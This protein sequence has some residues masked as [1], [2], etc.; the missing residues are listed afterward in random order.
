MKWNK[1]NGFPMCQNQIWTENPL[2]GEKVEACHGAKIIKVWW[3]G[4]KFVNRNGV[5]V[6]NI[7]KWRRIEK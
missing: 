1:R 7:T 5:E 3:D 2:K 6:H 4:E